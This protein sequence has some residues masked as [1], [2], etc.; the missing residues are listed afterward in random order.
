MRKAALVFLGISLFISCQIR[1][2]I[3]LLEDGSGTYEMSFEMTD[4][5]D[6]ADLT[7]SIP[8]PPAMDTLVVF[9]SFLDDKKDSIL[10]LPRKEQ[11]KLEIL[12]PLI[13]EMK[14]IDSTQGLAMYF[15][16]KFNSI[17]EIAQF[18]EALEMANIE[19]LNSMFNPFEPPLG[20][21]ADSLRR[22][23]GMA[24]L[25]SISKSFRTS[26]SKSRFSRIITDKARGEALQKKDT[27]LRADDSFGNIISFIQVYKFP[28]RVRSVSN[29][30]ARILPDFKGVEIVA[31][32]FQLNQDPDFLN[33]VVEFQ[34]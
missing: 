6:L 20:D 4:L 15:T 19:A 26:F 17:S 14:S 32:M 22:D 24:E 16:Y 27:T 10:Q 9:A 18:P 13:F 25:L 21:G 8:V 34:E 29:P 11:R 33:I 7:D 1:E 31:N 5:M 30:N 3:S 12:R 28:L 23:D 2:E